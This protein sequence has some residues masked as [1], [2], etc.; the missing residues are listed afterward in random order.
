MV[1]Q[2]ISKSFFR[3][4]KTGQLHKM[5][6]LTWHM[7]NDIVMPK[8]VNFTPDTIVSTPKNT[9]F[10]ISHVLFRID[11]QDPQSTGIKTVELPPCRGD[12]E[13][14][15]VPAKDGLIIVYFY[16]PPG[17]SVFMS[18]VYLNHYNSDLEVIHSIKPFYGG[19]DIT[20]DGIELQYSDNSRTTYRYD[21]K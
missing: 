5:I 21:S 15:L 17:C 16:L 8:W 19:Y 20:D 4:I 1:V 3:D 14:T 6:H 10:T 11:R 2:R 7:E 9:Y 12:T 13:Y 18:Q